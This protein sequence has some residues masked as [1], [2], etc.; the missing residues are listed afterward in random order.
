MSTRKTFEFDND[1]QEYHFV[2]ELGRRTL[3]SGVLSRLL[4]GSSW[5]LG[6]RKILSFDEEQTVSS[7]RSTI[8]LAVWV[9]GAAC[10]VVS[11]IMLLREKSFV[12]HESLKGRQFVATIIV[13]MVASILLREKEAQTTMASAIPCILI[14]GGYLVFEQLRI[15]STMQLQAFQVLAFIFVEFGALSFQDKTVWECFHDFLI[16]LPLIVVGQLWV[17]AWLELR[18]RGTFL[19]KHQQPYSDLGTFWQSLSQ[20]VEKL[21]AGIRQGKNRDLMRPLHGLGMS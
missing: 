17:T 18:S 13:A 15:Q 16:I 11:A 3:Y 6:W 12:K 10:Q 1:Y 7:L 14:N 2:E 20:K 21:K 19:Q 8:L 4:L 9:C 5:A